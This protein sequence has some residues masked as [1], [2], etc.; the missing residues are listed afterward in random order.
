MRSLGFNLKF[1][2]LRTLC[3][4]FQHI[5]LRVSTQWLIAQAVGELDSLA[6]IALA[7]GHLKHAGAATSGF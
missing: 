6:R 1:G 5:K 3:E 7:M 2:R 4:Q